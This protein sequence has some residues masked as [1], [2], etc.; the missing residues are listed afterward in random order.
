MVNAQKRI[1]LLNGPPRSGKDT[2]A[3]HLV[4]YF[5]FQKMKFAAPL[6]RA[7]AGL[8]DMS[9]TALE[10]H[11]DNQFNILSKESYVEIDNYGTKRTE[12]GPKDAP[13][14]LLIDLSESFLKPKYGDTFFGRLAT[15]EI[16]RSS[17][18]L[19]IF[20]D[21]GF[22]T[23]ASVITRLYRREN[24][25]LV[26]LHREGCTFENDSRSYLQDIAGHEVDVDNN[27]SLSHLT[28]K[29]ARAITKSFGIE[30]SKEIE[31]HDDR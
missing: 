12:Y 31:L 26:R 21:S 30:P 17:Y 2:A 4:P 8:L 10:E 18:N 1:V 15:R 24:V 13:R 9:V 23:E 11:K 5:A 20:T 27:G 7:V 14:R 28:G 29:V 3:S 25:L 6:K 19:I 16:N 22:A